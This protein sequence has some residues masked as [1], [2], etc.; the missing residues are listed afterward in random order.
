M[1]ASPVDPPR[2]VNDE[3]FPWIRERHH[4]AR[5][6]PT[7]S[8]NARPRDSRGTSLV[9][10]SLNRAVVER[11][12]ESCALRFDE[13]VTSHFV[14]AR[15][16][17]R[18]RPSTLF[19]MRYPSDSLRRAKACLPLAR[20]STWIVIVDHPIDGHH[21]ARCRCCFACP[22][23]SRGWLQPRPGD[24]GHPQ[25]VDHAIGIVATTIRSATSNGVDGAYRVAAR[26]R[27]TEP[28]VGSRRSITDSTTTR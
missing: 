3:Q 10:R 27:N 14:R 11:R 12:P 25:R 9:R 24:N 22:R 2:P 16:L 18:A 15:G 6:S 21:E 26:R 4:R 13:N 8:M 23:R 28:I 5:S 20:R 17:R 1:N 19:T 7:Q